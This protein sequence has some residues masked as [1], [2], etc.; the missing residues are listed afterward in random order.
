MREDCPSA[1]I[2]YI[3]KNEG[4]LWHAI[5]K[6]QGVDAVLKPS[7]GNIY[8]YL[9]LN[10]PNLLLVNI[11]ASNNNSLIAG[12]ICRWCQT[13]LRQLNIFIVNPYR[14]EVSDLERRWAF[15]RGA[16]DVLP[17]LT[18]KNAIDSISKVLSTIGEAPQQEV[19]PTLISLIEKYN[20]AP[21]PALEEIAPQETTA[22]TAPQELTEPNAKAETNVEYIT[23]RG[24]KVPRFSVAANKQRR[25]TYRGIPVKPSEND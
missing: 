7:L 6:L 19:I 8:E 24:V 2:A 1:L 18:S 15:R 14:S 25:L 4:L 21:P 16:I 5:L 10:P 22:E 20:P 12:S 17:Q 13:N 9:K 23:Y 3:D 11:N